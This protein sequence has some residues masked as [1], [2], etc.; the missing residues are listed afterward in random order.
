[1]SADYPQNENFYRCIEKHAFMH[2]HVLTTTVS[3]ALMLPDPMNPRPLARFSLFESSDLDEA[4]ERVARVFCPHRLDM[5][6]RGRFDA[7]HNHV[8]GER[9]SL[10]YIQYG[11]KTLI[12][13]GELKDFYLLQIPLSGGAA[14][15]NGPDH[16]YSCP[17]KAAV[18][19]P[20]L[21]TT[22]IWDEGCRQ[23]LVKV[24]REALQDHLSQLL[25]SGAGKPLTFSGP[26]DLTSDVGTALRGLIMHL[27]TQADNGQVML[28]SGGL[29][30]RQL[31]SVI[32]SG[33][34]EAGQHNYSRYLRPTRSA[35]APRHVRKAEE[36][37]RNNLDNPISLDDIANAAGVTAR[38]LQLGF[39]NFRNTS[40]M[41]LLRSERL[42][43]VHEE[44]MAGA[45][46]ASVT[47]VATRW[48]F[49]HLGR[50][51]QIYKEK[52]GQSP[53]TTLQ[54][55]LSIGFSD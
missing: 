18:L 4:R 14:I 28:S 30:A 19:N 39:R 16:Y 37:V 32:L 54:N 23:I 45:P 21:P 36:Y 49:S 11:A 12:A 34:L 29:L 9:L 17:E 44:L 51:S 40:P 26:L 55:G 48:G 52:Y 6:G 53:S 25:G 13:P 1:L 2:M 50:F 22:M 31:E 5:I 20:H 43:R 10:N 33:I 27:V 46:G 15:S 35:A 7:C 41:A 24:E 8:S 3:G 38:S 42:R 47:E